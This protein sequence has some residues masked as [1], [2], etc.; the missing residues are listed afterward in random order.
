VRG[1]GRGGGW[2][3]EKP[4]Y[5]IVLG[6][7]TSNRTQTGRGRHY[8][9]GGGESHHPNKTITILDRADERGADDTTYKHNQACNLENEDFFTM[10]VKSFTCMCS[11]SFVM[12]V[13]LSHGSASCTHA[14]F[15][16]L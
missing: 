9:V 4:F 7:A 1:S 12:A 2:G 8:L 11:I 6:K 10:F 5:N 14:V 3:R 16:W 13:W 15:P